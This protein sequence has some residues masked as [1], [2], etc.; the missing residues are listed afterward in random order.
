MN[1]V[2]RTFFG[3][4]VVAASASAQTLEPKNQPATDKPAD[5]AAPDVP[6]LPG[7]FGGFDSFGGLTVVKWPTD[8]PSSRYVQSGSV[9]IAWSE[10]N[11]VAWGFSKATGR[12]TK[13]DLQPPVAD[14][15][16]N[17]AVGQEVAV[18]KS[19]NTLYAYG[20][21]AGRWG[22]LTL[23]EDSRP[24]PAVTTPD[25]ILLVD[26]ETIHT[27]TSQNGA[28]TSSADE[29]QPPGIPA[30]TSTVLRLNRAEAA[31]V[32]K[33]I[34]AAFG[35]AAIVEVDPRTNSLLVSA[36]GDN[37]LRIEALV[38]RL[39]EPATATPSE[40]TQQIAALRASYSKS[41]SRA[42]AVAQELRDL[43]TKLGREHSDW[44]QGEAE[45][46]RLVAAAFEA[47]Q[48]LQQAEVAAL[49]Q[50]LQ[51]IQQSI[52]A[53]EKNKPA[54]IERRVSDLLDPNLA[55]E[56]AP[57]ATTATPNR[58]E[59]GFNP[60]AMLAPP[61]TPPTAA[62]KTTVQVRFTKPEG[63]VIEMAPGRSLTIPG[64]WDFDA[65]QSYSLQLTTVPGHSGARFPF[66][67]LLTEISPD[68]HGS[69]HRFVQHNAIPL[70]FT[71][72]DFDQYLSGNRVTKLVYFPH[73]ATTPNLETLTSTRLD[74]NVD[75]FQE[76]A[77]LGY[78]VAV[79]Q[80]HASARTF[81]TGAA[82]TDLRPS[83]SPD[84][85]RPSA[86]TAIDAN[87]PSAFRAATDLHGRMHAAETER[88]SL[89]ATLSRLGP[90]H[91][92]RLDY[93][94]RLEGATQHLELIRLEIAAQ[95]KLLQLDL[96]H[97]EAA[98]AAAREAHT[99]AERLHAKGYTTTTEL[100]T[101]ELAVAQAQNRVERCKVLVDLYEKITRPPTSESSITA[102]ESMP[103]NEP[104]ILG[105]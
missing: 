7:T 14:L 61:A 5:A 26:G 76:A 33:D 73:T 35:D 72:E 94:K 99:H 87:S 90:T 98:L 41:I 17:L 105:R 23:P 66:S 11:D 28:W 101:Q 36:A 58:A 57:E 82:A 34:R 52:A 71:A 38:K 93:A 45:L 102:P 84:Y 32:A 46:R 103:D 68:L 56:S 22:T 18:I 8:G 54:I 79:V 13:Q 86:N 16:K 27:F 62:T 50:R 30:R 20:A 48:Q 19:G 89:E 4:L 64:R 67:L 29:A 51:A 31:D 60:I 83:R 15:P 70:Q 39:D 59:G 21:G 78:V 97:A 43:E 49:S 92:Q 81:D 85:G 65:G 77:R 3:L 42:T 25:L 10:K 75:P 63:G 69:L 74:P 53:R 55:W 44:R 6:R 100:K 47:R 24:Q 2:L 104:K 40:I 91:P 1:G 80:L 88:E 12:W 95:L 9:I 37:F 96:S